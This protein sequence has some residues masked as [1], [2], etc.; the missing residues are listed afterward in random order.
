MLLSIYYFFQL[1][2]DKLGLEQSDQSVYNYKDL[3]NYTLPPFITIS[4]Q[5]PKQTNSISLSLSHKSR[6]LIFLSLQ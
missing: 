3:R 2:C 5:N 1:S 4:H 6:K